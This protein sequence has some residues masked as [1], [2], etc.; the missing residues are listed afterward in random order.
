MTRSFVEACNAR[1][2]TKPPAPHFRMPCHGGL[3]RRAG[4]RGV[5][6]GHAP[7]GGATL[8][9]RSDNEAAAK[10]TTPRMRLTSER[11]NR[12]ATTGQATVRKLVRDSRERPA[13][14]FPEGRQK[15]VETRSRLGQANG[16]GPSVGAAQLSDGR[17]PSF[18]E[19][20]LASVVSARG[21]GLVAAVPCRLSNYGAHS[22]ALRGQSWRSGEYTRS[23]KSSS[24]LGRLRQKRGFE[25]RL[26]GPRLF[27]ERV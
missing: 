24:G 19:R 14:A 2:H 17:L 10:R 5:T 8:R 27:A 21:H 4:F 11:D 16:N 7:S 1:T 15:R 22:G 23:S 9:Q 3:A 25:S 12:S 6:C 13:P 26:V 18:S 20:V